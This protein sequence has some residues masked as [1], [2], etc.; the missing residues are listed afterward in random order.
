MKTRV[1]AMLMFPL[2]IQCQSIAKSSYPAYSLEEKGGIF[3]EKFDSEIKD[4]NRYTA[5]NSVYRGGKQFVF[6]FKHISNENVV[7][8][9]QEDTQ[10]EDW[11]TNWKF[12]R[13][14]SISEKTITKVKVSVIPGLKPLIDQIPN[15]DQSIV[16]FQYQANNTISDI[17]SISGLIENEKNIWLHPPRDKYF[18]ILELNPFPFIKS[19][20]EIGNKWKWQL[21]IESTWGDKRWKTW[22]GNI[23]NRCD[24]EIV[25]I[26]TIKTPFGDLECLEIR[27]VGVSELGK[28]ELL[29]LFNAEFGFVELH[30]K[31]I[32]GSQTQLLLENIQ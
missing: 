27:S 3:V 29:A 22:E 24:Y 30:Y 7:Y 6:D 2:V 13:F 1:L 20:F 16:K 18:R 10:N 28:T 17:N 26:K 8:Y 32:D 19:P 21:E 5:N 11:R 4:E 15:Y 14:D 23:V 25:G 9:F 31:N 12:V